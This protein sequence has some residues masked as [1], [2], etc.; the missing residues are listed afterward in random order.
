MA[1][2]CLVCE[3]EKIFDG[4]PCNVCFGTGF[5]LDHTDVPVCPKCGHEQ[6]DTSDI[7]F[8]SGWV[9]GAETS[10]NC[11]KCNHKFEVELTVT[12]SFSTQVSR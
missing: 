3:G 11:E 8:K 9:D 12:Y 10:T 1:K 4:K 5:D 7:R 2:T 6:Q